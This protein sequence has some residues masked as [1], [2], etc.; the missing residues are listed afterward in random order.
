MKAGECSGGFQAP[1]G[2]APSKGC[3]G[4]PQAP[5][6]QTEPGREFVLPAAQHTWEMGRLAQGRAEWCPLT[7]PGVATPL[8]A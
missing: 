5:S 8:T 4:H 1:T 7:P 3:R 2:L 6:A